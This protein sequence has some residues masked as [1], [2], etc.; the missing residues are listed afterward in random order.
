MQTRV[1]LRTLSHAAELPPR[2]WHPSDCHRPA[3]IS[4]ALTI[5]LCPITQGAQIRPHMYALAAGASSRDGG[6]RLGAGWMAIHNAPSACKGP[7][8]IVLAAAGWVEQGTSLLTSSSGGSSD[9]Q[10]VPVR[11]LAV[12]GCRLA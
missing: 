6:A 2:A 4:L 9:G 10:E 7:S 8:I 5:P 1:P 11:M 3:Q 12:S